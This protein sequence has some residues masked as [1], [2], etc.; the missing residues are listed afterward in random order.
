MCSVMG[1]IGIFFI[2]MLMVYV[3]KGKLIRK[4]E[5]GVMKV[6]RLL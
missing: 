2:S 4:F 3:V 5:F 1:C 6:L